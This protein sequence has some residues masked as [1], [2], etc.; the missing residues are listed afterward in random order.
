MDPEF[1]PEETLK[2]LT[3]PKT[4]DASGYA[5]PPD[6]LVLG[7]TRE[8]IELPTHARIAAR[9]EGKSSRA[10]IG[11]GIHITA[12]TIH[13]GFKGRVRL[14]M[15]NHGTYPILLS[16][17]MPICQLVFEQ[18]LGTPEKGYSGIFLG[19]TVSSDSEQ[20]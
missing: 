19:Q 5:L 2:Q 14:E 13:A 1:N 7:W 8:Y 15:V 9:V 11:L 12:P 17:R 6:H 16:P 18:T 4:I 3:I 20:R 10:R